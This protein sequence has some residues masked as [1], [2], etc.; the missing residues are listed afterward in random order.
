ML[1]EI[2]G[3]T[4][5]RRAGQERERGRERAMEGGRQR[6]R[7][8]RAYTDTFNKLPRQMYNY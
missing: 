7:K 3:E 5:R 4:E 8:R 6:R 2:D 1:Y